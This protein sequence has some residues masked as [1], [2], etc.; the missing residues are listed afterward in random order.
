MAALEKLRAENS[1]LR[2]KLRESEL[3]AGALRHALAERTKRIAWHGQSLSKE[4]SAEVDLDLAALS[5][6]FDNEVFIGRALGGFGP[7]VDAITVALGGDPQTDITTLQDLAYV[8]R[9]QV[10]AA[11]RVGPKTM[12][13][14]DAAMREHGFEWV[15]AEGMSA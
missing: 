4:A 3:R 12:E 1:E 13:K 11:Q 6:K 9:A 5:Y 7:A 15:D 14:L 8:S 2:L 10:A